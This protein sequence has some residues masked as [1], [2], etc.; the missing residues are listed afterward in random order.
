MA[1]RP[2][3]VLVHA[4]PLSARMWDGVRAALG[5]AAD[6]VTPDVPGFGGRPPL[7]GTPSVDDLADDVADQ[8]ADLGRDR[9]VLG[10]LSMGGYVVMAFLRRH[11]GRISGLVLADTKAGADPQ[12]A[13]DNRE[14]IARTVLAERSARVLGEDVLPGLV[15]ATTKERRPEVL[16]RVRAMVEQA[17]PDGVA[18]AQRAMAARP[19]SLDVL[20]GVDVPALVVVG[21]EDALSPVPDAAAM[22]QALP[23]ARLV[24]LPGV[25][26]L[27]A[28]EHPEAFAAALREF[29][30]SLPH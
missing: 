21:A 18:W 6:V 28:V 14:R 26:H 23:A 9:V 30:A 12:P 2:T 5:P 20:R 7:S 3:L 11:P 29:L 13:R 19:D 8:V 16:A 22:A 1:S 27:S 24:V 17:D 25:G 15:G 4:F 10:G